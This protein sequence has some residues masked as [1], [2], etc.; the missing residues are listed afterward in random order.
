MATF[1]T[2]SRGP[3]VLIGVYLARGT[4]RV[5]LYVCAACAQIQL[6]YSG[7][8]CITAQ[9]SIPPTPFPTLTPPKLYLIVF[10]ESEP[11]SHFTLE[12]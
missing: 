9:A 5:L 11:A 8:S 1:P 3:G 12:I 4:P 2:G 6:K 10:A 7:F